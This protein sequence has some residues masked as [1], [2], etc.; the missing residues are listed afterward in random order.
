M[1]AIPATRK[2]VFLRL[3][4]GEKRLAFAGCQLADVT[5]FCAMGIGEEG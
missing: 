5:S 1:P 4:E 2:Y 3:K